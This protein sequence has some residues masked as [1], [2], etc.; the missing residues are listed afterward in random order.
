MSI[1]LVFPEIVNV[2]QADSLDADNAHQL[3]PDVHTNIQYEVS[4]I[5][6]MYNVAPY[7]ERCLDSVF[8]QQDISLQVIII[9]DGSTDQS[10]K[11]ATD[12]CRRREYR[13]VII[14]DQENRGLSA[15]RNLGISFALADYVAYL[16][17]DDFMSPNAY[18]SLYR[19]AISNKLDVVLCRSLIFDQ[20]DLSFSDF[21]DAHIWDGILKGRHQVITNVWRDPG[22]L[23][24]EPNANPRIVSRNLI[25]SRKLFYPEGLHFEDLPVHLRTL[26]STE[27]VGLLGAKH[28]MYRINRP[29]K[30]T[31]Q[32]SV[33]RFDILQIFDQTMELRNRFEISPSQGL[34]ILYS[35]IRI[36][37]WCGTQTCLSDRYRFFTEL[38]KRYSSIPDE[39]ITRFKSHFRN[40]LQQL[41][42]LWG[43]R[44]QDAK[45]LYAI[46]TGSRPIFRLA[47]FLVHQHRYGVIYYKTMLAMKR[48]ARMLPQ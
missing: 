17:T 36:T 26:F 24:F 9:N 23:M 28:Y 7:L 11:I 2:A 42:I 13:N 25:V 38:G 29:G 19:F 44:R 40:D 33:I 15:T 30:I 37:Y 35:L 46:S 39:W 31:D 21:Y 1:Q 41:I 4:L 32:K 27:R 43:L 45:L 5:L 8:G 14:I 47:Y 16:D 22:I 48:L 18:S 12:Y 6:P 20:R 34:G 10:L 3:L